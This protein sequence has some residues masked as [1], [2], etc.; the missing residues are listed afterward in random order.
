[1][2]I[3]SICGTLSDSSA[4]ISIEVLEI[5]NL[6]DVKKMI[7]RTNAK[8][9]SSISYLSSFVPSN[10]TMFWLLILY[11]RQWE[12]IHTMLAMSS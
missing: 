2:I 7:N 1:M 3:V 4:A 9:G 8:L 10:R 11:H 12:Q 5:N 6:F